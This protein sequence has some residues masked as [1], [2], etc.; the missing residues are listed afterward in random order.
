V[1][2]RITPGVKTR[3]GGKSGRGRLERVKHGNGKKGRD[4]VEILMTE[5][6]TKINPTEPLT[7]G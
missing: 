4:G 1:S 3:E 7:K 6:F 5:T 2:L